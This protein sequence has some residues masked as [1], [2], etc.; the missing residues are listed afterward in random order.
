LN[1]GVFGALLVITRM[2]YDL[3]ITRRKHWPDK[4]DDITAEEWLAYVQRDPELRLK[5]ENSPHFAV[6]SRASGESWL[7][8]S[9]GQI[10]TTNPDTVL[11]DKIVS[12]ARQF[13]AE[14]QGDDGE[15]YQSGTELAR[16]PKPSFGMRVTG[17]FAR[18][19]RFSAS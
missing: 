6:W 5:P 10:Y 18:S 4:G 16:Q 19:L 13:D 8:W 12:I 7:E 2:G 3:H 17:W 14:V 15:I 9:D 11:I 1:A